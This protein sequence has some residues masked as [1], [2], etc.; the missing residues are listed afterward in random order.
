V[1]PTFRR[2]ED[3]YVIERARSIAVKR[4]ASIDA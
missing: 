1:T 4:A 2:I 3:V